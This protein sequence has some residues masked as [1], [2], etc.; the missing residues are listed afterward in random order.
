MA[1][2]QKDNSGAIFKNNKPKSEKSPPQTGNAMIGGVDYWISAWTKIDK[3][4]E[5]W[6]SLAFSPKNPTAAQ[7]QSAMVADLDEDSIPF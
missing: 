1:Y 4:G 5:K 2:E 7:S 3:N 6:M